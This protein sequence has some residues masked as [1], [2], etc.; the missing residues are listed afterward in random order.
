MNFVMMFHLRNYIVDC[1]GCPRNLVMRIGTSY[2]CCCSCHVELL[3]LGIDPCDLIP[4][5]TFVLS[6]WNLWET[7]LCQC[8]L[9]NVL[10]YYLGMHDCLAVDHG[11]CMLMEIV[12]NICDQSICDQ[13]ICNPRI[14]D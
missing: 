14:C 10:R 11:S 6:V 4:N 9:V 1:H 8:G 7:E 5:D 2:G 3:C 13:C 12:R